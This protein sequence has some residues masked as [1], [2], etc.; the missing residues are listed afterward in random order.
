MT[1]RIDLD[2]PDVGLT[3]GQGLLY[4]GELFT[5]EAVEYRKDGSLWTLQTYVDG[6]HT[7]PTKQWYPDGTLEE[8][9]Q[10]RGGVAFGEWKSWYPNGQLRSRTVFSEEAFGERILFKEQWDEEGNPIN[11][12]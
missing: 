8:E 1:L 5:G 4:R 10:S 2:G 11:G 9:G 3:P 7:G 12:K 6:S